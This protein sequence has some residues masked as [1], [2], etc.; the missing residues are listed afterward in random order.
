MMVSQRSLLL[1][2]KLSLR[3]Q[4]HSAPRYGNSG[5]QTSYKNGILHITCTTL[6]MLHIISRI[7]VPSTM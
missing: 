2:H 1:A 7:T 5:A 6:Y 4:D 3:L